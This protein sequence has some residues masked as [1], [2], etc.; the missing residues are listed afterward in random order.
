M[1]VKA[2]RTWFINC[3]QTNQKHEAIKIWA[4]WIITHLSNMNMNMNN[5]IMSTYNYFFRF[6]PILTVSTQSDLQIITEL[7]A[8]GCSK[9]HAIKLY[10]ILLSCIDSHVLNVET[11]L[12]CSLNV[13]NIRQQGYLLYMRHPIGQSFTTDDIALYDFNC[14]VLSKNVQFDTHTHLNN[15]RTH[16]DNLKELIAKKNL[17]GNVPFKA[18]TDNI[19]TIRISKPKSRLLTVSS[20][21]E[22][23]LSPK[24]T[25]TMRLTTEQY[26]RCIK[27]YKHKF[28][29]QQNIYLMCLNYY[30]LEGYS[31]QWSIPER[32]MKY[33]S[34]EFNCH[35]ELF[36]SPL[37]VR[38]RH[39][40]SLFN[41]DRYFGSRGNFFH[42]PDSDFM[43]GA[44]EVNAPFI[45]VVFSRTID[46]ILYLLSMAEDSN[47]RLTFIFIIPDW[48]NC[49]PLNILINSRFNVKWITL[50]KYK[51][52]YYQSNN[53][54]YIKVSFD[55]HIFILSTVSNICHNRIESGLKYNWGT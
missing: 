55:T 31:L 6:L 34:E 39:Y 54:E 41:R 42:A 4:R 14:S 5:P 10:Q 48:Q 7:I 3:S 28:L 29:V 33:I 11:Y 32:T 25:M 40:Y 20:P 35:T 15:K 47:E 53:H 9:I 36:A 26:N 12:G 27:L 44:F 18:K 8:K 50:E 49:T 24:G 51:H 21:R 2:L 19:T 38:L 46:R 52:A 45:E 17:M 23:R 37:N 22:F 16:Q 1:D 13:H 30:L 43:R